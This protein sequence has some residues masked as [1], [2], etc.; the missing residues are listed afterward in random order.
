MFVTI[1]SFPFGQWIVAAE[2]PRSRSLYLIIGCAIDLSVLFV[3]KY[4]DFF[5]TQTRD[6]MALIGVDYQ[7]PN[8]NLIV[9]VAISFHTFQTLSYLF[10]VYRRDI[11]AERSLG[12]FAL[13]VVYY[14][15]LVAGPIERGF[16]FLPQLRGL[17]A[18]NPDAKFSFSETRVVE[19]LRLVLAGFLKKV[20]IADNLALF[21]DPAYADPANYSPLTLT[22][23]TIAFA[24]ESIL[25]FPPTPTSREDVR[26]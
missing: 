5:N 25:I 20:V 26:V 24:Y 8:L 6:L 15:Q 16:H 13:Y 9:P 14:P 23:A 18:P 11:D 3:F 19:G 10:D 1:V 17:A 21:V 7:V 22:L 12:V 2:S 4:V